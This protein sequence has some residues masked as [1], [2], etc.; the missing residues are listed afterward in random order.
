MLLCRVSFWF[1]LE[2]GFGLHTHVLRVRYSFGDVLVF[3]LRRGKVL[4]LCTYLVYNT[5][6]RLQNNPP[7]NNVEPAPAKSEL[8]PKQSAGK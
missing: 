4:V 1:W 3:W 6:V 5:V 7:E 8:P 2:I